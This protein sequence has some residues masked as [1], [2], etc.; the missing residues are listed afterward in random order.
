M[1]RPILERFVEKF[2]VDPGTGCWGWTGSTTRAAGGYG[3]IWWNGK[4]CLAH[5]AS[6]TLYV[7]EIP[8]GLV[9]DHLC[10]NRLCVNPDHL[11]AVTSKENTRRGQLAH[12]LRTKQIGRWVVDIHT[13]GAA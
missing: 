9:I 8:E 2:E 10:R 5:R 11:E 1:A 6:H 7:G 3:Q 13:E 4:F 12:L